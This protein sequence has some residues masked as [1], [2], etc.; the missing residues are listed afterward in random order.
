[1]K[2]ASSDP[3]TAATAVTDRAGADLLSGQH[4]AVI[5]DSPPG[6]GKSTFVVKTAATLAKQQ[7]QVPIV[8]QTNAQ[9]DDLV[10]SLLRQSGSLKIGRLTGSAGVVGLDPAD[11]LVVSSRVSDLDDCNV[12]VSTSAKWA[13]VANDIWP[14]EAGIIDEA[15]QMRSDQLLYVGQI[16]KRALMVGDPGQLD[17]FSPIDDTRWRGYSDGPINPA[18]ATVLHNHPDSPVHRLPVS[19]RLPAL[20]APLVSD[21]FYPTMPFDAGT[22]RLD[23]HLEV[24]GTT[25]NS[26]DAA[27][28]RAADRGWLFLELAQR[29]APPTD[30]EAV[31]VV[32]DVVVRLLSLSVIVHDASRTP[33]SAPLR[34][35]QIAVGVVHRSQRSAI[36]V[37]VALRAKAAGLD[38]SAVVVDT[39]NRLQ[40]REFD[41]VVVL[42]PL[43][44]RVAATEFH[45]ETG[46]LCVLLSRH[47]QACIVVGRAG[48]AA[49]LD[50][51]PGDTPI[52][53]GAPIPVPDGWEANQI[54]IDRLAGHRLGLDDV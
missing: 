32:A 9:A 45:L 6:A 1:M 17:P 13:Y 52:W 11:R 36:H 7:D 30:S 47:R 26:I 8:A 24:R 14:Y 43:S 3:G 39:A 16:F 18:I 38:A 21:A 31:S 22:T 23:R 2:A 35:D 25:V 37:E 10:R 41:V 34:A 48:I 27:I 19:W 44:G 54:V 28:I 20:C 53:I 40:G 5:V 42:H 29:P 50:A 4:L 46:R 51:H 12:I 49:V 15:Y 33:A